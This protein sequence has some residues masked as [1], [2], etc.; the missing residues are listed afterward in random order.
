MWTWNV[1]SCTQNNKDAWISLKWLPQLV[2]LIW[3]ETLKWDDVIDVKQCWPIV[4]SNARSEQ[5]SLII[6]RVRGLYGKVFSWGFR[7]DR[8]TKERGLCEK[9]ESKYF[10]V[11][12]EQTR[13]IRHL[14]YGFWL[15][16]FRCC[17][18]HF[19]RASWFRFMFTLV[20]HSF[21]SLID[22]RTAF[23]KHVYV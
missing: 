9:T 4:E 21:P 2:G 5:C 6:N 13:L 8:A 7:T 23:N 1:F 14:L 18:F 15:F 22:K 17:R 12:S 10:P 3:T 19:L 20:R 16:C 11:L